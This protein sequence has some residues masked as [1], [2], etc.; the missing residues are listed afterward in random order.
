MTLAKYAAYNGYDAL[1]L[2]MTDRYDK[3][4]Y[5]FASAIAWIRAHVNEYKPKP[6]AQE[7]NSFDSSRNINPLINYEN[8][9]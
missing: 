1:L 2:M 5:D 7:D 3:N 8:P 6:S 9:H 4:K